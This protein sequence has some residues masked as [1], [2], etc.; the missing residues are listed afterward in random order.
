MLLRAGECWAR[1]RGCGAFASD[2]EE[3]LIVHR[4]FGQAV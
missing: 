1:E 4:R 2:R 3:R